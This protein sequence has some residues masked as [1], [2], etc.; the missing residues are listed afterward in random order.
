MKTQEKN[1]EAF[2]VEEA[3]PVMMNVPDSI[4]SVKFQPGE[5]LEGY[6]NE[7][8]S[9]PLRVVPLYDDQ[10]AVYELIESTKYD[11]NRVDDKSGAPQL[12]RPG[13]SMV[14][15][16]SIYDKYAR[17]TV[18]IT[19]RITERRT[20]TSLGEIKNF[21]PKPVIFPNKT[22]LIVLS[23]EPELYAFLERCDENESNPFRNPKVT[24]VFK[25]V[26]QKKRAEQAIKENY[27]V[28]EA[29]EWIMRKATLPELLAAGQKIN[30]LLNEKKIRTNY[31]NENKSYAADLI[32]REMYD[33]ATKRSDLVI[34]ASTDRLS[35]M[36]LQIHDAIKF[37]VIILD[38]RTNKCYFNAT[39]G[40]MPICEFEIGMTKVDSI[41]KHFET[42]KGKKDH[43]TMVTVLKKL[44]APHQGQQ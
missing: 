41:V 37:M 6:V 28:F 20:Q 24:P 10:Q 38:D 43:A 1:D 35:I 44:L 29:Q 13:R 17:R 36:K 27:L 14:G 3:E 40:L 23:D 42:E 9:S 22:P 32:K 39:K 21:R 2:G 7:V 8:V 30:E 4:E 25:R 33:F 16:K 34:R 11:P 26:D 31:D 5:K 18:T 15:K 19:T 12:Q